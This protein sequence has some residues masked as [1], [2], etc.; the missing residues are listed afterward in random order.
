MKQ[1]L[2]M[3]CSPRGV[4]SESYRLSRKIVDL[5]QAAEPEA[6]VVT[7]NLAEATFGHVD[8]DYA[9][10]Q[11]ASADVSQDGSAAISETLI[12][13]LTSANF[14]VI[15][16]PV[17]NFTVPSTLKAWIDHVVRVRWTFNISSAGKI[18]MLHD[19]PVYIAISSGGLFAGERA[20]QPDFLRPYLQAVLGIIGLRDLTFFSVQGTAFGPEALTEA[21]SRAD[22]DLLAHFSGD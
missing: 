11:H 3:T 21:R 13:E 7:R 19:R 5:L 8:G 14:I 12:Q 20:R 15:G 2:H 4:A 17:H 1:I 16:T 22:D 9:L 18:G 6:I 10:S